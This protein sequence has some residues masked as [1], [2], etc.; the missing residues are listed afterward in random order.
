MGLKA[1]R[2]KRKFDE[3]TEPRGAAAPRRGPLRFVIQKHRASRL[4]YDLRLELDGTMKSWAVPRGPSL[5]PREKRLAILVEDHPLDYRTF[6]GT[7]PS[8][9]YGAGTVMVW[10]AGTYHAFEPS[11]FN[12]EEARLRAGLKKGNFR[13][14]VHGDK[15]QGGFSL[16]KLRKASENSWLL[17]KIA[18][19]FA[20][21]RD[22]TEDELSVLS[23]RTMVEIAEGIAR[24]GNVK[25]STSRSPHTPLLNDAPHAPMPRRVKPMLARLVDQPF[26]RPGWVFEPKWDGYRAIA[27]VTPQGISFY[28]RNHVSFLE[29]FAP[30]VRALK[31]LGR[32]AVYDGEV[33]VVDEAGKSR[34]QLL[35]T[36]QK[37]GKG[38]LLYYVFDLLYL[39]GHDLRGLP[40]MERKAI[41]ATILGSTGMIRLSEHVEDWGIDFFKVAQSM[42]LEGIIA[43]DGASL[44]SQ[45]SRG[46]DWLKIKTQKRQEAVIAG[47]TEP[48]GRRKN[49]GALILGLYE[50]NELIYIGHTGGGFNDRELAGLRATLDP[51]VRQTSPFRVTPSTN[52]P[53][54]WVEPT[55][56]CEIAFQEWTDSGVARHPIFVGLREDKPA[57]DVRR[58]VPLALDTLNEPAPSTSRPV[59]RVPLTNKRKIYWPE[60][61]YTKGDLAD[62]YRELC[63]LILPYLRDRPESLHRHPDGIKAKG[64][65]QKDMSL[66]QV[67]EWVRTVTL[68]SGTEKGQIESLICDD[69]DTLLYLVN[70]GC[71]EINPWNS[72]LSVLENPD[73]LVIDLDPEAIAFSHVIEAARTVRR[74]LDK[75]EILSVCKTSGKTGL[76]IFVPL[77]AR[78]PYEQTRQFAEIVANL[79]HRELP[80]TT[81]VLRSPAL[82]QGRIYLDFLQNRRGQTLAAPY[83]ARPIPGAPVSTPLKW[84]EVRT[85]LDPSRFTIRTLPKRIEKLGDLWSPVL[86]KGIELEACLERLA[87]LSTKRRGRSRNQEAAFDLS[88]LAKR[89]STAQR[90]GNS[91]S[92]RTG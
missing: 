58:E 41:L 63:P 36:Y 12:E 51:L 46:G 35:Q 66:M 21:Q 78:Y 10:D 52:A 3:T 55:L 92:R 57:H 8:G 29:P 83:S 7:I 33:V 67:P 68:P 47:F 48:K 69:R 71:I 22:V 34:F 76:H 75:A 86:E 73:Y 74:L 87:N 24:P 14:V 30:I 80:A 81:S 16:L 25:T 9:N 18:D 90:S 11:G 20:C 42:E 5:D 15:L 56:V 70:L 27:E 85:G 26:D 39:D 77:G 53:V 49:L 37:T 79:V 82:R 91:G 72:R 88:G 43:K 17:V 6:E 64:F 19:E 50:K 40:L 45:G 38:C 28:S 4:H 1:Y 23:G 84:S 13:F 61:G 59:P 62:Y 32:N 60:D 2:E 89:S 31:E 65:F 54:H 44:Y